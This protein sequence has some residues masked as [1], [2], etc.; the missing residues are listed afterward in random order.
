[1]QDAGHEKAPHGAGHIDFIEDR[2][3]MSLPMLWIG[4]MGFRLYAAQMELTWSRVM[5]D[6][7]A[8][9]KRATC[10]DQP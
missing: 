10:Q 4:K 7:E 2:I 3:L 9:S 5:R 6:A 8:M 1:M